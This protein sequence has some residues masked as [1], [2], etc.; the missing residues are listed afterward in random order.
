MMLSLFRFQ[1]KLLQT[2][3]AHWPGTVRATDAF[4]FGRHSGFTGHDWMRCR[5]RSRADLFRVHAHML[6]DG[7]HF[8][9]GNIRSAMLHARQAGNRSRRFSRGESAFCDAL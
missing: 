5:Q 1:N 2:A 3:F 7:F 8:H 4:V 6:K 9:E